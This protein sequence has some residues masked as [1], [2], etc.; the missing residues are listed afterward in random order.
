M[1]SPS[2]TNRD[3]GVEAVRHSAGRYLAGLV[4]P[5]AQLIPALTMVGV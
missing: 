2:Y 3:Y 1:P 5:Q 4:E